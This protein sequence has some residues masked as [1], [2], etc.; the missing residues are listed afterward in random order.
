[1][2]KNKSSELEAVF[3]NQGL[4]LTIQRRAILEALASRKDHPTADQVYEDIS[5]KLKGVSRTTVYRV[6]ETFVSLGIAKK[7]SNPESKARFDADTDRHHHLTC[8]S[9]GAVLDLHD[10][11]LNDLQPPPGIESEF[12]ILDYSITFIGRC[13]N[14]RRAEES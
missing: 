8:V 11:K 4:A 2:L 1:M 12:E 6:L 14:C 3:R 10:P 7:I 13:A 9:C 5:S